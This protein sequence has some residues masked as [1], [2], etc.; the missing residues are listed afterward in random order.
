MNTYIIGGFYSGLE[1]VSA[2]SEQSVVTEVVQVKDTFMYKER[3]RHCM[4]KMRES[5]RLREKKKKKQTMI[6]EGARRNNNVIERKRE[7]VEIAK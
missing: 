3:E 5:E 6:N 7:R 2:T 4:C 1:S